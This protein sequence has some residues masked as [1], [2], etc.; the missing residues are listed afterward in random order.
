MEYKVTRVQGEGWFADVPTGCEWVADTC[1]HMD[2]YPDG[3]EEDVSQDE[4]TGATRLEIS[5]CVLVRG[6]ANTVLTCGGLLV[7]IPSSNISC[8]RGRVRVV[9]TSNK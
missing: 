7:S 1:T 6:D 9:F 8:E 4:T 5:G 3:E 2:V